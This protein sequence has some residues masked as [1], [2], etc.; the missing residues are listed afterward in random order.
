MDLIKQTI[1]GWQKFMSFIGNIAAAQS[2]KAIGKYNERMAYEEAAY[3]RKKAAIREKIYNTIE[4]P[5]FVDQQEQAYSNFFVSSLRTGA[6]YREGTTP[7]LVGVRN[8]Q[9]QLFDLALSDYNNEVTVNDQINQSLLLEAKGRG[10][11]L[12]GDLTARAEYAKAAGSLLSM[13]S[14]SYNQG[15]LVIV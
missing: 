14:Q 2:A 7:F 3:A 1:L 9:N 12:K 15:R 13:G 5:R 4:R 10:E 8:K 11:R 6:E